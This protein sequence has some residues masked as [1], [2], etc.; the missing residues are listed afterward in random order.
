MSDYKTQRAAILALLIAA[1]GAW[2]S[3]PEIMALGI[4]QYNSRILELRRLNF[5]VQNRTETIHG[6]R[7]SWYRLVPGPERQQE[8]ALTGEE[9]VRYPG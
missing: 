3:L 4:A 5:A 9:N 1:K 6:R 8:L 2:V 7:H